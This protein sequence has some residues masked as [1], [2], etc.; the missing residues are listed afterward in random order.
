MCCTGINVTPLRS[1]KVLFFFSERIALIS[2][3]HIHAEVICFQVQ[4]SPFLAKDP[5]S[6]ESCQTA[7]GE[8]RGKVVFLLFREVN[9]KH[10]IVLFWR[11]RIKGICQVIIKYTL[12]FIPLWHSHKM[13]Y[14]PT[15]QCVYVIRSYIC[16]SSGAANEGCTSWSASRLFGVSK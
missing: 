12:L 8:R 11:R 5:W 15:M 10:K 1:H 6:S 13:Y 9:L 7:G 14:F 16:F 4:I 2:H 3:R